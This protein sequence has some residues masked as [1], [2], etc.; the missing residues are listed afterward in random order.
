[1]SNEEYA[2]LIKQGEKEFITPL[3]EQVYKLMY[4]IANKY[5]SRYY[6]RFIACGISL[7]DLQ[8]ECYFVFLNIVKAYDPEKEYKLLT[9]AKYQFKRHIQQL[10][11]I[12]SNFAENPLNSC[13]SL[14]DSVTG[15]EDEEMTVA[16]TLTDKEAEND[17][18]N[19]DDII[20]NDEL[21]S[22]LDNSMSESLNDTEIEI[23]NNRYFNG[24][25][26]NELATIRGVSGNAIRQREQ[27]A[28]RKLRQYNHISHS[29]DSFIDEL[30][31]DKALSSYRW[32]SIGF[33]RNK[34]ASSV[35]AA[36]ES[37]MRDI[38]QYIHEKQTTQQPFV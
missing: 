36:Y 31:T 2:M 20:F 34:Q 15:Y 11:R 37:A 32:S 14:S 3:W 29:L 21:H 10:L 13:N 12:G 16:D 27:N 5:Y 28:L 4:G 23:L 7:E 25:T 26:L 17:F 18:F 33:F 38:E 24:M 9:Y 30:L 35:E 8:Q 6:D 1:M 22:A 19:I